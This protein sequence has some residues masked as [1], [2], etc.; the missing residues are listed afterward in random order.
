MRPQILGKA[1]QGTMP[2]VGNPD[3]QPET[4]VNS[5]LALYWNSA[6]EAHDFN[7]TVFNNDFKDKIARGET[8]LSCAQTGGVRP[9]ANLGEYELLGYGSYAQN[10]NIGEA[11]VRGVEVA[12]G[13][14]LL[15]NL[16]LRANYTFTDSEQRTGA[17]KGLPLTNTAEHMGNAS[18]E[19]MATDAFAM[20][21][22]AERR[23]ERYRG[24]QDAA[25]NPLYYKGYSV[26][27]LAAQYRF[28]ENVRLAARI[29]NLLDK[30]FTSFQTLWNQDAQGVYTPSYLDDYNNKDKS[31]NLWLS[32]NVGF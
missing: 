11:R 15:E 14:G 9:C 27:H 12:G 23:S 25:G 7:L 5:E 19:W 8:S 22:I 31:R 2:F 26:L 30:D 4:S 21:L 3:L 29:N 6:D 32:L 18:L 10:I 13:Y 20:Q 28:S 17:Q 1:V 16:M 24:S